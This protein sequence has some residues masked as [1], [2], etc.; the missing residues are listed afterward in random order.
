MRPRQISVIARSIGIRQDEIE[1]H[2]AYKAKVSLSILERLAHKPNGKL[3]NITSITP[4]RPGEGKTSTAIGL[5][6]A[7]AKLKRNVVLCLREPSLAPTFGIKGGGCGSG[8]AQIIPM[9]D[10]N[11]HFTRDIYAVA[12][13]HN[14]SR[15]YG[16]II[17]IMVT[18]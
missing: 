1:T 18:G 15:P 3:I 8:R 9:D 14:C 6:E 12:S 17:F 5:T 7:L 2:G 11:L 13:A 4:T 16:I 10:I